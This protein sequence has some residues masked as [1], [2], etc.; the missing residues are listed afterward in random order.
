MTWSLRS[1]P[2]DCPISVLF[3]SDSTL[4]GHDY[5]I[6]LDSRSG[7]FIAKLRS[8]SNRTNG[9]LSGQRLRWAECINVAHPR[10][11]NREDL[12]AAFDDFKKRFHNSPVQ[13]ECE[14]A[15]SSRKGG[16]GVPS[17]RAARPAVCRTLAECV[18]A[19][20]EPT[21]FATSGNAARLQAL[22]VQLAA[23]MQGCGRVT[24][25][26]GRAARPPPK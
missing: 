5:R 15:P 7:G 17:A 6:P 19:T 18:G 4:A 23:S 11:R 14:A 1:F 2:L 22:P 3:V 8:R 10:K 16:G 25:S 21:A 13:A 24:R 20:P 26:T 12:E 9:P